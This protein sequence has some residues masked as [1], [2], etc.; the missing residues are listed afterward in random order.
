MRCKATK[1]EYL[2]LAIFAEQKGMSI[3]P[4]AT[5][6]DYMFDSVLQVQGFF[7]SDSASTHAHRWTTTLFDSPALSIVALLS[8]RVRL[9]NV[10]PIV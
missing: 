7:V 2:L 5:C 10:V 8:S 3:I 9:G 1:L 4:F 6:K